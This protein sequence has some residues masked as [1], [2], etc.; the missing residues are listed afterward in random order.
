MKREIDTLY[1][2][3]ISKKYIND[4]INTSVVTEEAQWLTEG[5][6]DIFL[7]GLYARL[8]AMHNTP[9]YL[10]SYTDDNDGGIYWRKSW[11]QM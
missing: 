10:D 6:A 1:S 2:S 7:N 11:T 5:T 8:C 3:E 9:D 4:N